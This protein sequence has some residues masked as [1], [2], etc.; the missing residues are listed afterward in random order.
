MLEFGLNITIA[1]LTCEPHLVLVL[2]T[3]CSRLSTLS[4]SVFTSASL[5]NLRKSLCWKLFS[6]SKSHLPRLLWS[7]VLISLNNEISYFYWPVPS[8]VLGN[9]R[10]SPRLRVLY[11]GTLNEQCTE[12]GGLPLYHGGMGPTKTGLYKA[13]WA[14]IG[15]T[16]T[17]SY[18]YN[19]NNFTYATATYLSALKLS[20]YI[21][22]HILSYKLLIEGKLMYVLDKQAYFWEHKPLTILHSC[23]SSY[24]PH[25]GFEQGQKHWS[26]PHKP[27]P[28]HPHQNILQIISIHHFTR[29]HGQPNHPS[30]W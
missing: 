24:G 5:Q 14:P 19:T 11:S 16:G 13:Y 9:A 23:H 26:S 29:H 25:R 3:A 2:V 20:K 12:G 7:F 1:R 17:L 28:I 6:F 21:T 30:I 8:L 4:P 15:V 27:Q 10:V 18:R 22:L